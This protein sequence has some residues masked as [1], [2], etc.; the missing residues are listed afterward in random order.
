MHIQSA[1]P[2]T[3]VLEISAPDFSQP[4]E[5]YNSPQCVVGFSLVESSGHVYTTAELLRSRC[6]VGERR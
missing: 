5:T 4:V 3:L 1:G 6:R 2:L